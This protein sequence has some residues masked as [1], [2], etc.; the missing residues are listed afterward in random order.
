[1]K[2]K[3]VL[4]SAFLTPFRSGAEACAEEIA[5]RLWERFD[6]TIVTARLT[7][8]LPDDD[9]FRGQA[10]VVRVGFGHRIDKW[11]F[12]FLAPF[13]VRRAQPQVIH[14][15]LESF[16]GLAMVFSKML[17]PGAKAILTCQSTNTSFLVGLM[18]RRA[19]RVTVISRALFARAQGFG[20]TDA[21]LIPNGVDAPAIEQA[22]LHE[23]KVPGRLLFVGRLEPMKGVDT[24]LRALA[25]LLSAAPGP[26]HDGGKDILDH[27]HLRIVGRGSQEKELQRLAA[28]LGIAERVTFVGFLPPYRV[29]DE[30]AQAQ[31]F[32]GLSRSEALGNVFL[33][34][35]AAGCAVIA[36]RTGGIPDI[37]EDGR[38]GLLVPPDDAE[39]AAKAL[40]TLL[41]DQRQW[42]LLAEAG[43][44]H[45]RTYDWGGIVGRY[46]ETY[47]SLL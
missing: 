6:I 34:A 26:F 13:A 16:A 1:M 11:L 14:A 28:E 17:L 19:D 37:V 24:L 43:M 20:R 33:E 29:Y 9:P 8:K 10:K 45:A 4:L 21:L 31:I 23:K 42:A 44:A 38:T 5:H 32:C 39:A 47:K 41:S 46:E 18:H 22:R 35:Q 36:T 7:K 30:Y 27:L 25:R 2:Q 12:P 15:V 3:V 40:L